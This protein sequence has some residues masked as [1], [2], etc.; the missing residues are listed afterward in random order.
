MS[1]PPHAGHSSM[2]SKRLSSRF[3]G[4]TPQEI[5]IA[6]LVREGH[7]DKEIMDIL[8]I[9]FETIKTHR[10]HLRK[11]LG[12]YGQRTNLRTY[13]AELSE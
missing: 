7:Q 8:N 4:L 12:I 10:Q 13:L 2:F 11:K 3:H 9:S 5:R 6:G 1:A